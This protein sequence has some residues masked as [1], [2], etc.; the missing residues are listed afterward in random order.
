MPIYGNFLWII[1]DHQVPI[2][3]NQKMSVSISHTQGLKDNQ[4]SITE[5]QVHLVADS[6]HV[7]FTLSLGK[8]LES[9]EIVVTPW[10]NAL[11]VEYFIDLILIVVQY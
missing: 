10:G 1:E 7:K 5:N 6:D 8:N 2:P 11:E 3:S 4:T 9:L